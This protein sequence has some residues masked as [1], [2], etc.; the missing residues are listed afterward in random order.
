[1]GSLDFHSTCDIFIN[2]YLEHSRSCPLADVNSVSN[3]PVYAMY[4]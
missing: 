2:F 1:M 3:N 4:C